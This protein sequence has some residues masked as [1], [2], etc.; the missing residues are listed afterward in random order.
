MVF[1]LWLLFLFG[2]ILSVVGVS[3]SVSDQRNF[4]HIQMA[5]TIPDGTTMYPRT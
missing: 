4:C 3:V 1:W 5:R 2:L